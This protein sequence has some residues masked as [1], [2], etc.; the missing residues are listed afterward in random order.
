MPQC[1]GGL[2][3]IMVLMK[4]AKEDIQGAASNEPVIVGLLHK[5]GRGEVDPVVWSFSYAWSGY[6]SV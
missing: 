4:S 5:L 1:C 2:N 3:M 6:A